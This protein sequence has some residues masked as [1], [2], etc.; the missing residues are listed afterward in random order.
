MALRRRVNQ[1]LRHRPR[2]SS[3]TWSSLFFE[4][5]SE[6]I[7]PSL[8]SFIYTQLKTYSGLETGRI[9]P[10][11]RLIEDLRFPLVCWFDWSS[12][13][14]DDFYNTFQVDISDE[15]DE[16]LLKTVSD[17]VCFLNRY[18]QSMDSVPS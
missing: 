3:A 6:A 9:R 11:D 1:Q 7:S 10:S 13:L 16:S 18:L 4:I 2:L 8:L 17:L 5:G 14:C 12:Q 15:F